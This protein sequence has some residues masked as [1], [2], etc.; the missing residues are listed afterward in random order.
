MRPIQVYRDSSDCS[1]TSDPRKADDPE[2]QDALHC[3]C[4]ATRH[5]IKGNR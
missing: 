3:L 5:P 1:V 2:V 4:D